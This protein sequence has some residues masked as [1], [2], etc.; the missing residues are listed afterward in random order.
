MSDP[1]QPG[2]GSSIPAGWYPD[3]QGGQRWWDGSQWTAHT[4]PAGGASASPAAPQVPGAP[5]GDLPTQI[6]PNRASG[7]SQQPQASTPPQQPYG[8]PAGQQQP[9]GAPQQ[10]P[11]GG[12]PQQ[13]SYGA[14]GGPS[15]YGAP[16]GYPGR[17][18]SGGGGR[19]LLILIGGG[20]AAVI[21]LIILLVVAFSVIGGGS[22][23]DVAGDYFAA[24][25]D[26]DVEKLCELSSED[27]QDAEFEIYDVDNCGDYAEEFEDSS[28]AGEFEDY[29]DDF[30]FEYEIG[31][32]TERD[33]TA[34]VD[35][36]V[37]YKY[38]GDDEDIADFYDEDGEESDGTLELVKEDGEWK[39]DED[40][41]GL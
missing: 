5:G 15:P 27:E 40:T 31:D 26:G 34:D 33:K 2:G 28:E 35:Y 20:V 7:Y 1:N 18:S 6:A 21:V 37:T 32:V 10:Q 4:Q 29:R 12:A 25:E 36:T 23:E 39:V 16:G 14:P 41:G 11:Y 17:G 22:P 3:G 30:D 19:K 8:A 38:T 13:Q 24:I 9:Y